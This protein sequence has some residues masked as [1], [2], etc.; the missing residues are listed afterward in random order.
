[1]A[2]GSGSKNLDLALRIQADLGEADKALQQLEQGLDDVASSGKGAGKAL[3]AA[4]GAADRKATKAKKAATATREAAKASDAAAGAGNKEAV[5]ADKTAAATERETKARERNAKARKQ[6][7]Q[8]AS[9]VPAGSAGAAASGISDAQYKQAMRQLPMQ[10]TDIVSGLATGQ[11]PFMVLLQQGGQLKDSFGGV[12]KAASAVV[13]AISPM[14]LG[15]GAGAA[16][17]YAIA[18]AA[19]E[20]YA[21]IRA[22]DDALIST[23][24]IAGKTSGQLADMGDQVGAAT[25]RYG[26][27]DAA[28]LQMA[29]SGKVAGDSLDEAAGAAVNLAKLTGDSIEATTAKIIELADAPTKTLVKLNDQY[30]FLTLAVYEHV[31]SLE[32]QGRAEDAAR[33]AIEEF[34]RVHEQRVKEAEARAGFLERA[35]KAVGETVAGVWDDMKSLGRND[36]EGRLSSARSALENMRNPGAQARGL[37]TPLQVQQQEQLVKQ[38]EA[39]A[40][41]AEKA[42]GAQRDRQVAQDKAVAAS[43]QIRNDLEQ[44]AS[45]SEKYAAAVKKLNEQFQALRAAGGRRGSKSALL[46]EVVFG[47]DGSISG[48]AYDKRL[49]Q[50]QEQ[51]KEAEKAPK[52]PKAAAAAKATPASEANQWAQRELEN[53]QKM[54]VL[55]DSLTDGRTKATEAARIEFE[56]SQG[57]GQAA[58]A[59]LQQQLR[60]QATL[61]DAAN[62][63]A[64]S[65]RKM[66]EVHQQLIGLQGGSEDAALAKARRELELLQADLQKQGRLGDAAEVSKLLGLEQASTDL[67]NLRQTYDQVMGEISLEAQRIQVEQQAGLIT[68]ADAQQKIVDLYRSRLGTL[69]EL[70]PQMRAAAQALGGD[71]GKAALANVEQIELKLQEMESTTNAIQ[72]AFGTTFQSSMGQVLSGLID[73]TVALDNAVGKFFESLITGM[74]QWAAQ[75]L[76]QKA[77]NW[78]N[79]KFGDLFGKDQAAVDANAPAAITTAGTTA[80]AAI[81]TAGNTVAGAIAAASAGSGQGGQWGGFAPTSG[82]A[83]SGQ[84]VA[85]GD[86]TNAAVAMQGAG[87]TVNAGAMAIGQS[88][89]QLAAAAG[90]LSPGASSIINAAM[91]LW[92]AAQTLLIANT[93]GSA[94]GFGFAAGGWTGP[95]SKY[96][97]TGVVHAEEFV[98]RR[99]VVR[100]P[101]ALPF[102]WDFNRRGMAALHDWRGYAD[103]GLVAGAAPVYSSPGPSYGAGGMP[104][105]GGGAASLNQRL[106][107]V[108]VDDPNRIPAALKSEVGEDSFLYHLGRNTEAVKQML[109]IQN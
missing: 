62:L 20:G 61:A 2:S 107:L 16:A 9:K 106:R 1:M 103:G 73:G 66:I 82:A 88:A 42:A 56:L 36:I 50:L 63:R 60:D 76:A 81:V 91:Q 12:S 75:D 86:V 53:L 19:Y 67:K 44:G 49:K 43:A 108:V 45:K 52:T 13:G 109:G 6:Q 59:T 33:V 31:K 58:D 95:G 8:A 38:L 21:E 55:Q 96:K 93:A 35:W 97:A 18:K 32:D 72:Q 29:Q 5:A 46:D 54:V 48:G 27:A 51:F 4:A 92:Q 30:H 23:G 57:A 74:A 34:A 87:E 24:G 28:L 85:T 26:E 14:V 102:L 99:E 37:F 41:A 65:D 78:A 15:L 39:E 98:H 40:A 3:D 105:G 101:G 17:F 70:V 80:A 94:S 10:M 68:E 7:D 100:Q 79:G 22:Y 83:G 89:V 11:S 90:G 64:E 25:G 69:R 47:A 77:G 104:K 84:G 71:A